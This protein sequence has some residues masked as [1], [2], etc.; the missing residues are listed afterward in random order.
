M[1]RGQPKG[2]GAGSESNGGEG[3]IG[4]SWAGGDD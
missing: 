4:P 3:V 2:K 1:G